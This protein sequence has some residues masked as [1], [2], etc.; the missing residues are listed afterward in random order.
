MMSERIRSLPA[1][2]LPKVTLFD[3]CIEHVFNYLR[4][5]HASWINSERFKQLRFQCVAKRNEFV[6]ST[7]ACGDFVF[8]SNK[9]ISAVNNLAYEVVR[10]NSR[11]KLQKVSQNF[12]GLTST[13]SNKDHSATSSS[14]DECHGRVR[15]KSVDRNLQT[16]AMMD[17]FDYRHDRPEERER[18]AGVLKDKLQHM[19]LELT[20]TSKDSTESFVTLGS[21]HKSVA[22][23]VFLLDHEDE[24]DSLISDSDDSVVKYEKK[25]SATIDKNS[26]EEKH[27]SGSTSP[28]RFQPS[29]ENRNS[30]PYGHN[31]FAPP[32]G[33]INLQRCSTLST[34]SKIVRNETPIS[35]QIEFPISFQN[36]FR[37]FALKAKK[38]FLICTDNPGN[39]VQHLS[40]SSGFCS[41]ESANIVNRAALFQKARN[42]A[43]Q[44]I[45][46]SQDCEMRMDRRTSYPP[47]SQLSNSTLISLVFFIT[48]YHNIFREVGRCSNPTKRRNELE[49]LYLSKPLIITYQEE[50]SEAPFV[51]K[52]S[53]RGITYRD[54][55]RY[56]GIPSRTSKKFFF[57]SECE[58]G[59]ALYQWTVI[60]DDNMV[61]PVFEGRITA[62]CRSFSESD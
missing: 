37:D 9:G 61:L 28:I 55:R 4:K 59:S 35:R 30:N 12:S 52:I 39:D 51:A 48:R 58:D 3:P 6:P 21:S 11:L 10:K 24:I 45:F 25:L 34:C 41:S 7:S 32:P 23:S 29:L 8:S 19:L 56:F 57:K 15:K 38:G 27:R 1:Y 18:F 44:A 46:L 16:T 26:R 20:T 43:S 36:N 17:G 40:D 50:N 33:G 54:F 13:I 2:C 5:Q 31:K 60:S 14:S 49:S 22:N 53:G 62:E 42:M 47:L